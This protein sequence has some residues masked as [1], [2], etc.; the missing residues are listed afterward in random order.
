MNPAAATDREVYEPVV[1]G[2]TGRAIVAVVGLALWAQLILQGLATEVGL[3]QPSP[4]LL[5]AYV[6]PPII[7]I[8]G[9]YLHSLPVLLIVAPLSLLPAVALLPEAEKSIFFTPWSMGRIA[10]TLA[11]YLAL[12]SAWATSSRL[13]RPLG[14]AEV[15]TDDTTVLAYRNHILGRVAPFLLLWLVPTYAIY[16]DPAVAGTFLQS[17]GPDATVAQVFVSTVLFLLWAILA[18]TS[19]IVPALNLEYD[20]RRLIRRFE[21]EGAVVQPKKVLVRIAVTA[22]FGILA[23]LCLLLIL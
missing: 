6:A 8:A 23:S 11:L 4:V 14:R 10:A 15:S 9:T 17:F 7:L 1:S 16:F 2:T 3:D 5:A 13:A 21:G 12:A 20:R 19:F 18:Y 22:G